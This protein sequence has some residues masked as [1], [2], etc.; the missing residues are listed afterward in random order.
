MSAGVGLPGHRIT[1]SSDTA[2]SDS[3][4]R[5]AWSIVS[6]SIPDNS[7][8]HAAHGPPLRAGCFGDVPPTTVHEYPRVGVSLKCALEYV[9][10]L[11]SLTAVR[12]V[13]VAL[14][15]IELH[16]VGCRFVGDDGVC[17]AST[18][19]PHQRQQEVPSRGTSSVMPAGAPHQ[20]MLLMSPLDG[21][22]A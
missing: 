18:T 21:R 10:G 4:A 7:S 14:T 6:G 15:A 8:E 5:W 22:E 16:L 11:R 20:V 17:Q 3:S 1:W 19:S 13:D 9:H 12:P 2:S